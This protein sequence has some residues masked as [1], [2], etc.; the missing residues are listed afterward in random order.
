ML[1]IGILS[2]VLCAATVSAASFPVFLFFY[3]LIQKSRAISRIFMHDMALRG[4]FF[5]A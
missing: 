2:V 5:D 1:K 3:H 4:P